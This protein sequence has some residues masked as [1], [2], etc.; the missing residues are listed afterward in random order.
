M[1]NPDELPHYAKKVLAKIGVADL[2]IRT[3]SDTDDAVLKG[4]G[5]LYSLHP[6]GKPLSPASTRM[7]IEGGILV[8]AGDGLLDDVSQTYRRAPA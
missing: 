7:L 1:M 2:V 6:G 5:F 8:P 3:S 4:G